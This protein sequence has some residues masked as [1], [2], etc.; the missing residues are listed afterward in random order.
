MKKRLFKN[1]LIISLA[2]Y[3][4]RACD[5]VLDVGHLTLKP[6]PE[7]WA[8]SSVMCSYSQRFYF[9]PA[10]LWVPLVPCHLSCPSTL[11]TIQLL[12]TGLSV[13]PCKLCWYTHDTCRELADLTQV[14][15]E[16]CGLLKQQVQAR[17]W[18]TRTSEMALGVYVWAREGYHTC[19]NVAFLKS[20]GNCCAILPAVQAPK[21][22]IPTPQQWGTDSCFWNTLS[23]GPQCTLL[24]NYLGYSLGLPALSWEEHALILE[25]SPCHCN[26]TVDDATQGTFWICQR[27][28]CIPHYYSPSSFPCISTT[29]ARQRRPFKKTEAAES[30]PFVTQ[31]NMRSNETVGHSAGSC[32]LLLSYQLWNG[33]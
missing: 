18:Y 24:Q 6:A 14:P 22:L 26:G 7:P 8:H 27:H 12:N 1:Y 17:Q 29:H 28:L 21:V 2:S 16:T 9:L 25:S 15:W 23:Q 32:K 33:K 11:G 5:R 19:F 10:L 13:V 31:R 4:S 3:Y 20:C 30:W